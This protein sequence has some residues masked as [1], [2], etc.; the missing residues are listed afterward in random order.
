MSSVGNRKKAEALQLQLEITSDEE[1]ESVVNHPGLIVV[2]VYS[3]WCGPCTSMIHT[4]RRIKLDLGDDF[5]TMAIAC[6]DTVSVLEKF[7]MKAEPTWLFFGGGKALSVVHGADGPQL[8]SAISKLLEKERRIAKGLDVRETVMLESLVKPEEVIIPDEDLDDEEGER[9]AREAEEAELGL[10]KPLP[11]AALFILPHIVSTDRVEAFLSHIVAAGLVIMGHVQLEP[12][13]HQLLSL[14]LGDD[15]EEEEENESKNKEGGEKEALPENT[16]AGPN[17]EEELD[18]LQYWAEEL[19]KAPLY[20]LLL[21]VDEGDENDDKDNRSVVEVWE[22]LLGPTDLEEAKLNNPDCLVAEFGDEEHVVPAWLP[23]QRCLQ[24]RITAFAFP[25]LVNC[26]APKLLLLPDGDHQNVLERLHTAGVEV[27]AH[28]QSCLTP[29][30]M[31]ALNPAASSP[32]IND[33]LGKPVFAAVISAESVP[34]VSSDLGVLHLTASPSML[35]PD[36]PDGENS[37]NAPGGTSQAP[38][39]PVSPRKKADSARAVVDGEES[40]TPRMPT[41][42]EIALFFPDL[43]PDILM[44]RENYSQDDPQTQMQIEQTTVVEW[45]AACV[46]YQ[47]SASGRQTVGSKPGNEYELFLV[48]RRELALIGAPGSGKGTISSRIVRDFGL[49]HLS[50]GDLLRNQVMKKTELGV[51]AQ[52]YMSSGSLVPDNIVV[53]LVSGELKL[54]SGVETGWLLDGFPRTKP[55]A[56]ALQLEHQLDTVVSLEVPHDVI[57]DRIKGRWVHIPSG[58]VYNT[59]FNPPKKPGIDDVTGE[60]LSQRQDDQPEAVQQ[61]LQTYDK[62][63]EPL[64]QYYKKLGILKQFH[65]TES[66]K[67][68]PFV[69]EHIATFIECKQ[70]ITLRHCLIVSDNTLTPTKMMNWRR[71]LSPNPYIKRYLYPLLRVSTEAELVQYMTF[72]VLI[73]AFIVLLMPM[74]APYGRY[75]SNRYGFGVPAR[76][77][78]CVQ[79]SPAFIVPLL[80][81]ITTRRSTYTAITNQICMGLFIIHYFQRSFVYSLLVQTKNKVPFMPCVSAFL[82]CLFFG[83]LQSVYFVNFYKYDD[84]VWLRKPYFWIGCSL[85]LFGMKLNLSS[86]SALRKL[87][88]S[89]SNDYKIPRGGMFEKVSCA[90]YLGEVLEMWGYAISSCAP[91]AI[92]HAL[93]TTCFLTRRALQH[94]QLVLSLHYL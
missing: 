53:G 27:L 90:N 6:S 50:V 75:R 15:K 11:Y 35:R 45:S 40:Q 88:T 29:I 16:D 18:D 26:D 92:A 86:D 59:D 57:I 44:P 46:W 73:Y 89:Q 71:L 12:Q 85:Y 54:L 28:A 60:Q 33:Y 17:P 61:R 76:L 7:R 79:E 49:K 63:T 4:L 93:F 64:I 48:S 68:W 81:V 14:L 51:K 30:I 3:A 82:T 72:G 52:E 77:A 41:A 36:S 87:R 47:V 20:M 66:N 38:S 83:I 94:H 9:A 19:S 56:E 78:W 37:S 70:C 13:Q 1:W 34:K 23:R 32:S 80:M 58:R 65:G 39:R 84:S 91:P 10:M 5:L 2:D 21:Q 42:N 43:S 31:A 69:K 74:A 55:Q 62:N 67:I 8:V 25:A 22:E 24:E